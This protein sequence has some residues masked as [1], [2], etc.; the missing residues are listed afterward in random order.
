LSGQQNYPGPSWPA[1]GQPAMLASDADRDRAAELLSAAFA[2]GRLT[3]GEHGDRVRAAYAARTW[4]QLRQLT[5]DLPALEHAASGRGVTPRMAAGPDW[6]LLC[7]LLVV[8]PPAGIAWLWLSWR[9]A[10]ACRGTVV[11]PAGGLDLVDATRAG[12]PALWQ[13]TGHAQDR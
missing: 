10:R 1:A 9:R 4:R 3:A 2:E 12:R 11:V 13:E 7:L 5:D 6:C 8:C